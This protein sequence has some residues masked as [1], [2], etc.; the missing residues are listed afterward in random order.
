MKRRQ[1][2]RNWLGQWQHNRWMQGL[3]VVV[4]VGLLVRSLPYLAPIRA[5]DM[6]HQSGAIEFRDRHNLILGTLLSRDQEHT[7]AVPLSQVSPQF[8]QA[9]L[10]A[11]DG[12]FYRHGALEV[13][14]IVR[15]TLEA[16]RHRQFRSGASTIT[17]QLARMVKPVPNNLW[18][19][20]QEVWLAWRIAA[21]MSKDEIL[22]AY[23]NRIPMGG[24]IYGVEAAAR[25]YFGVAARDLTLAQ[26]S[27]LA[28]LPND[29]VYLD[30][31]RHREALRQRQAYVLRRMVADGYIDRTQADAAYNQVLTFQSRHQGILAA[32]HF[33][34]WLATQLPEN[35]IPQVQTSLDRTLQSYIESQV[36]Q[37]LAELEHH[38]VHHAAVLVVHNPTGEVLAYVG[39][40]SYLAADQQGQNDGVQ[41][42]RQPGSSL[43]PF[44]YEL[45]LELGVIQPRTILADVPTHYAIPGAKLY[46]PT[47]Y[48]ETFQGPVRVRMALANS[49][50]VP[51][52]RI[53]EM[54]GVQRFLDRLH[55]LGF[56]HLS[57]PADYYGLGLTLGS[58]EVTLWELARAYRVLALASDDRA[59]SR[60]SRPWVSDLRPILTPN[61][62][63]QTSQAPSL[64]VVD[65]AYGRPS[66]AWA[67]VTDMLSDRYARAQAFGVDSVLDLPFPTAVKTGTSS[68]F[69]D[70]WTIGFTR[71][72]TVAVWVGNFDGSPMQRI[73]GVTGAAPLW[74]RIMLHLHEQQPPAPF[75]SPVGLQKRP[76]CAL[77]GKKPTPDCDVIVQEYLF[78]EDLMAYEQEA[79][80]QAQT[81]TTMGKPRLA[82]S[83]VSL[84]Q[85]YDEWLARQSHP[86][87]AGD[88]LRIVSPQNSSLFLVGSRRS[89][90]ERLEF[91]LASPPQQPI[92]WWLN[93]NLLATQA[94]QSLFWPLRPGHWTLEVRQGEASDRITFEVEVRD[95]PAPNRGFSYQ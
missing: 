78:P 64:A 36:S 66:P 85:D 12:R 68:D 75:S 20:A 54:V 24:N 57:H 70:T 39:S 82:T 86:R 47:D 22:A 13:R 43:K 50:N 1:W 89:A 60:A 40:P 34:L 18:G 83:Q 65:Q 8:I 9:I 31:Y 30:P 19:K 21:G 53:L 46:S 56:T 74:Q 38:N 48:S 52:V 80:S 88:A 63:P 95:E 72:Y 51:A 61:H 44:L 84:S 58:G 67:L 71:D 17:M 42:L 32:P 37:V 81:V 90:H 15:S 94:S 3:L 6:A 45:A 33:L 87:L 5:T 55:Q 35:H 49:L 93:G 23:I 79:Q 26:A 27:L 14:A 92:E 28:A 25:A 77:T 11:E 7:V 41:A 91:K 76:I 2:I 29:P 69:R 4:L 16:I 10:A 62:Q 59:F 73:S